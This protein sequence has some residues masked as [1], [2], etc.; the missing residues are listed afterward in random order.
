MELRDHAEFFSSRMLAL[1]SCFS[2]DTSHLLINASPGQQINIT[3]IDL[4]FNKND[5]SH[6]C[7]NYGEIE[8]LHTKQGSSLCGGKSRISHVI[9]SNSHMM[10]LKLNSNFK[11]QNFILQMNGNSAFSG[12]DNGGFSHSIFTCVLYIFS[13]RLPWHSTTVW[14][15]GSERWELNFCWMSQFPANMESEMWWQSMDWDTRKLLRR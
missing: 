12:I 1:S 15:M 8:D 9:L 5:Q 7:V 3:L 11:E 4:Q 14:L 10:R 2:Q 6:S 13:V